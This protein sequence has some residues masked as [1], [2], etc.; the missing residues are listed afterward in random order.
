MYCH[1]GVEQDDCQVDNTSIARGIS[2]LQRLIGS[3]ASARYEPGEENEAGPHNEDDRRLI[4]Q[5]ARARRRDD[6]IHLQNAGNVET[7]R[8]SQEEGTRIGSTNPV[9]LDATIPRAHQ[10]CPGRMGERL[11]RSRMPERPRSRHETFRRADVRV[12]GCATV[13]RH[14]T[15]PSRS[16]KSL[17][18]RRLP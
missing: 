13:G 1:S 15:K 2:W 5:C 8:S 10:V 9:R 7:C 16:T 12:R 17:A 14:A 3:N 18:L 11:Q 4:A 6:H